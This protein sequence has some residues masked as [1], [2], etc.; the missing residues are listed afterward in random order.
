MR[1][2]HPDLLPTHSS[3]TTKPPAATPCSSRLLACP[4]ITRV[5][6]ECASRSHAA[7]RSRI[8]D[9]SA[10]CAGERAKQVAALLVAVQHRRNDF[11]R[12]S[13]PE[14]HFSCWCA[15]LASVGP[16]GLIVD[17]KPMGL[18][19]K[20]RFTRAMACMSPWPYMGLSRYMV[21]T[22]GASESVSHMS[23]TSRS[24]MSALDCVTIFLHRSLD[25]VTRALHPCHV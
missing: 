14:R 24:G 2:I 5:G 25:P 20:M 15:A 12:L 10:S 8:P 17:G 9:S 19:R 18:S 4:A 21:C 7:W 16:P 1:H 23:R 11:R 13:Q 6:P 22:R 3:R